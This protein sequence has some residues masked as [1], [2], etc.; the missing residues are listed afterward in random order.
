MIGPLQV[1]MK[2]FRKGQKF[3]VHSSTV[4]IN[5]KPRYT[6][7]VVD[8]NDLAVLS[9]KN[10]GCF[11]V[12]LGCEKELN[13]EEFEGQNDISEQVGMARLVIVTLAKGFAYRDME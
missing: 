8:S 13:A 4:M 1:E 12:P 2:E 10:M 6:L 7:H 5:N 3:T 11:V 9:K